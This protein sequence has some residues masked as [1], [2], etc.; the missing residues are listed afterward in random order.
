MK[1]R[2][3]GFFSFKT[4]DET[5][6]LSLFFVM[7]K[8]YSRRK[9]LR[10]PLI[11]IYLKP[12]TQL[13]PKKESDICKKLFCINCLAHAI[14]E[15]HQKQHLLNFPCANTL[16][17]RGRNLIIMFVKLYFLT[18]INFVSVLRSGEN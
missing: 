14:L 11:H 10:E 2:N 15:N 12:Y 5:F 1:R 17:P 4:F 7:I 8:I 3:E 6:C 16:Q 13:M 18:L 9:C